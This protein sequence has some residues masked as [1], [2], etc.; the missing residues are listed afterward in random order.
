MSM[1]WSKAEQKV[2]TDRSYHC[3]EM[4]RESSLHKTTAKVGSMCSEYWLTN[5][6]CLSFL[7]ACV[8]KQKKSEGFKAIS[9]N[10]FK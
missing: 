3:V 4:Q 1:C 9:L 2:M 8:E 10:S 7:K 6:H 5:A